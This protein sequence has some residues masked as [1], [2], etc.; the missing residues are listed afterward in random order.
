MGRTWITNE[1]EWRKGVENLP[2]AKAAPARKEIRPRV[3][4]IVGTPQ[5]EAWVKHWRETRGIS[6]PDYDLPPDASGRRHRGH[7]F[8]SEWPPRHEQP[9]ELAA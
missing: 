4:V 3:D 1:I 5:W 8:E 9:S 7:S 6:P 2:R